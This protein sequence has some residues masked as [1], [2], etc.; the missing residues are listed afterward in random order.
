VSAEP[1]KLGGLLREKPEELGVT[2][3]TLSLTELLKGIELPSG[4]RFWRAPRWKIISC[5]LVVATAA[6]VAVPLSW[7]ALGPV[8]GPGAAIDQSEFS[9]PVRELTEYVQ[10]LKGQVKGR[11]CIFKPNIPGEVAAKQLGYTRL[12]ASAYDEINLRVKTRQQAQGGAHPSDVIAGFENIV[13]EEQA[14]DRLMA[15]KEQYAATIAYLR[16]LQNGDAVF[17]GPQ[18]LA[19]VPAVLL[20]QLMSAYPD[21]KFDVNDPSFAAV[22]RQTRDFAAAR[23]K[24]TGEVWAQEIIAEFRRLTLKSAAEQ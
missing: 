22:Y 17:P 3:A 6:G 14:I 13:N 24:E 19:P 12:F 5:L 16:A 7:D 23:V 10:C 9:K 1:I 20:V 2:K 18:P 8:N 11:R 21:V 4:N 15:R